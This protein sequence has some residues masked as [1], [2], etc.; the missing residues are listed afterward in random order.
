MRFRP[1]AS[2]VP[3]GCSERWSEGRPLVPTVAGIMARITGL[4][5]GLGWGLALGLA[6]ISVATPA[7]AA[8]TAPAPAQMLARWVQYAPG[9][10]VLLRAIVPGGAGAVCPAA[11]VDGTAVTLAPRFTPDAD[12]PV[13][14]CEASV[15]PGGR[16]AT[17]GGATLKMPVARPKRI[18]VIGDTGCRIKGFVAQACND[19]V[20]FPLRRIATYVA[21]LNADAIVHV[22][23]YS[24]RESP[25]PSVLGVDCAGS[26]YGDTWASW[27]ADWFT[28]AAA[29]L[30]SAPLALSRGNHESCAR[31]R[32]GWF[33]LLDPF[34]FDAAAAA[35]TR[36]SSH[37]FEPP[38]AVGV[39]AATLLMFDSS[40]A[41]DAT[42]AN[43][44]TTVATY[45]KELSAILPKLSG[46]VIMVTHKPAYGLYGTRAGGVLAGGNEDEQALFTGGVPKPIGLLLAGHIHSFQ[47]VA[48]TSADYAPQ[49][50]VGNSGTALDRVFVAGDETGA[51]YQ[52]SPSDTVTTAG[53]ADLS[54]F[55]FAV[56]DATAAGY[57]ATI[58][59]VDSTVL[60]RCAIDL[61]HRRM[62]CSR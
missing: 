25:C 8:D 5:W 12:F 41:N 60:A 10:T 3:I 9:D 30:G 34:A 39:G 2:M 26:P 35:C 29:I 20:A 46:P 54:E 51:T 23:D 13:L 61:D 45:R 38:Y 33:R 53:T 58:Y 24:Y 43:S 55:G 14:E 37:E 44:K 49:L 52:V 32:G 59:D 50:V 27:D 47:A 16:Q 40:F 18:V 56:L 42:R 48:F 57:D 15:P 11:A 28:P 19:P 31:S 62:A 36:G 17:I 7:V 22:G 4:A 6:A 21:T 1:L